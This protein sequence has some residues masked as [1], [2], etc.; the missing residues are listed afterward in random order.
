MLSPS[1]VASKAGLQ[2]QPVR[3]RPQPTVCCLAFQ[4]FCLFTFQPLFLAC[5]IKFFTLASEAG[6][7][8]QHYTPESIC[9]WCNETSPTLTRTSQMKFRVTAV[10]YSQREPSRGPLQ[11]RLSAKH[12][13]S[14]HMQ[15]MSSLRP[16][17]HWSLKTPVCGQ[18]GAA[19]WDAW[20]CTWVLAPTAIQGA[21]NPTQ[22]HDPLCKS[23]RRQ[24]CGAGRAP[25]GTGAVWLQPW[26]HTAR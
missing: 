17:R 24:R 26:L 14:L 15:K 6:T 22:L 1:A 4:Y 19:A 3:M 25:G 23:R 21:Q 12:V 13:F 2:P 10:L 11:K 9:C 8:P 18:L 20:M 7:G 5:R 16:H